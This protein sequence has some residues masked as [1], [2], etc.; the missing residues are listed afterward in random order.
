MVVV[1]S[2]K[3]ARIFYMIRREPTPVAGL[4]S[5]NASRNPC[6]A[7]SVFEIGPGDAGESADKLDP[8]FEAGGEPEGSF[9]CE[10]RPQ[11]G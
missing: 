3:S 5:N 7:T 4:E 6:D 10:S 8:V 9:G 11:R 1:I 2:R